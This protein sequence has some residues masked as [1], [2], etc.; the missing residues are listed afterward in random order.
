[1]G[2]YRKRPVE[3]EAIRWTGDNQ[4]ELRQLAHHSNRDTTVIFSTQGHVTVHTLEGDM[5]LHI[6][7]WLVK[8]VHGELYPVRNDIFVETYE[9]VVD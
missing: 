4:G 2:R 3:I 8:G 9:M 1:M 5:R 7:D 6:G